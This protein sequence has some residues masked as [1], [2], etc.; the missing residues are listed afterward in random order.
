LFCGRPAGGALHTRK[1][2]PA[3]LDAVRELMAVLHEWRRGEGD[4]AGLLRAWLQV[5]M[6]RVVVDEIRYHQGG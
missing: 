1:G 5:V 4:L 2:G 3:M 6:G